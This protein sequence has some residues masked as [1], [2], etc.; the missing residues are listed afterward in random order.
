MKKVKSFVGLYI[1]ADRL[2]AAVVSGTPEDPVLETQ[3]L[4]E[5]PPDLVDGDGAILDVPALGAELKRFW[6]EAGLRNRRVVLVIDSRKALLRQIRLPKMPV[7]SLDQA[8]LSEAEQFA[9]FR[10][11]EPLIDYFVNE[12]EHQFIQTTYGVVSKETVEA[13]AKALKTA[14]LNMI[15]L[16]L[17]QLAGQRGMEYYHPLED[18]HWTGVMVQPQR[19]IISCWM[20]RRLWVMREIILPERISHDMAMLAQSYLPN[21]AHSVASDTNTFDDPHMVLACDRIEDAR[22]LADHAKSL[23]EGRISIAGPADSGHRHDEDDD[24][25][26]SPWNSSVDDALDGAFG[27]EDAF[28]LT[29][30]LPQAPSEAEE[31]DDDEDL[32]EDP[33]ADLEDDLDED[34]PQISYIALGAAL[35]GHTGVVPSLN[36]MPK[37]KSAGRTMPT[38]PKV[39]FDVDRRVIMGLAATLL[40]GAALTGW[41]IWQKSERE[42]QVKSLM[43]QLADAQVQMQGNQTMM[44]S[45]PPEAE[46][47]KQWN[48]HM[49]ENVFARQFLETLRETT[50]SDAWITNVS[51]TAGKELILSGGA[52]SQTSC[53][54]FADQIAAL[55]RVRQVKI[56]K[57]AKTGD[58]YEFEIQA[59]LGTKTAGEALP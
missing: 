7:N 59:G 55:E 19:L 9:L 26:S 13:Y 20:E 47:L 2:E 45:Q 37:G 41:Q 33:D 40:V 28:V 46:L 25:P 11:E 22:V 15:A 36:L 39:E 12:L 24:E 43:R 35:W 34:A 42:T 51:Y 56:R 38:L 58:T 14:G 54:Y 49:Q 5:L 27:E 32:E 29:A 8:I 10:D 17:A 1:T 16:D 53:L 18:D 52:L 6:K 31:T 3:Y 50:P 57:I 44:D 21:I 23:L 4:S 30:T 48:P